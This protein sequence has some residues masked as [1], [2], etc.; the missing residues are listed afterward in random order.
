MQRKHRNATVSNRITYI[1]ESSS[2]DAAVEGDENGAKLVE[3]AVK[4]ARRVIMN[5]RL[6]ASLDRTKLSDRKATFVLTAAAQSLGHDV[7]ELNIN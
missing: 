3:P 5:P 1:S 4:R 7:T 6:A 2:N